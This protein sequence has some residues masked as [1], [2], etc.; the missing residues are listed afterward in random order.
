MVG[1]TL[2]LA[3]VIAAIF[4]LRHVDRWS[5]IPTKLL[6]AGA[7]CVAVDR[8]LLVHETPASRISSAT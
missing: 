8:P 7:A 1:A 4:F 5:S 3:A 6:V 2:L